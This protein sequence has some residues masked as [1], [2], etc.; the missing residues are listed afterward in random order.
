MLVPIAREG[1][2]MMTGLFW[3]VGEPSRVAR[4]FRGDESMPAE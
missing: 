4:A 1:L 3:D 2:A